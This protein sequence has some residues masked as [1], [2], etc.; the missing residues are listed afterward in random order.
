VGGE[1]SGVSTKFCR[2]SAGVCRISTQSCRITTPFCRISTKVCRI[3]TI[4]AF[5]QA[6]RVNQFSGPRIYQRLAWIYRRFFTFIGDSGVLSAIIHFYRRKQKIYRP[7]DKYRHR[8]RS[9]RQTDPPPKPTNKK[10]PNPGR[11]RCLI[12]SM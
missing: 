5:A 12:S 1:V 8:H 3:S 7:I 4:G 2:L 9:R 6:S 11:I 10:A